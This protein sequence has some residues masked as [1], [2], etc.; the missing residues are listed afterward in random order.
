MR[1]TKLRL[2]GS[3]LAIVLMGLL[4]A[5]CQE[6]KKLLETNTNIADWYFTDADGNVIEEL[7]VI[8][9]NSN[10]SITAWAPESFTELRMHPNAEL[11]DENAFIL[12]VSNTAIEFGDEQD[13]GAKFQRYTVIAENNSVVKTYEVQ[14]RYP[15]KDVN[16]TD[17]LNLEPESFNNGSSQPGGYE[18][19][20]DRVVFPNNYVQ[21]EWGD[22]WNGFSASNL[23]SYEVPQ[24]GNF[25]PLQYNATAQDGFRN[26]ETYL[27]GYMDS[28]GIDSLYFTTP[29]RLNSMTINTSAYQF[30]AMVQG[31]SFTPQLQE[32]DFLKLVIVGLDK[33]GEERYYREENLFH[34][35]NLDNK[36]EMSEWL[37]LKFKDGGAIWSDVKTLKFSFK[38]SDNYINQFGIIAPQYICIA[39]MNYEVETQPTL[40]EEE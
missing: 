24:D 4:V 5:S 3:A 15:A 34:Y 25:F 21:S 19:V 14:V 12:P 33:N 23:T 7:D 32:F 28:F 38:A 20:V 1:S 29:V 8:I 36:R 37:T 35:G 17:A 13:F 9:D 10:A 18:L 40:E 26:G 22:Y 16:F 30:N 27:V 39:D 11:E 31:D 6:P 2:L